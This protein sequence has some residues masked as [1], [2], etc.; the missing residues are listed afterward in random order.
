MGFKSLLC[1]CICYVF[2]ID[3]DDGMIK[4]LKRCRA[5]NVKMGVFAKMAKLLMVTVK[6]M[7][8]IW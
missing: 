8:L 1:H 6:T 2:E 7:K 3:D 5:G 4:I